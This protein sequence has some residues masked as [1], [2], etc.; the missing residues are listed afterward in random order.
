MKP[1]DY[2]SRKGMKEISWEEFH[3]MCKRLAQKISQDDFDIILGIARGGLYPATLIAGMLRKEVY[4]IRITRRENDKVKWEKPI[5]K[6]DVPSNVKSKKVLIIDD[7]SD[8]GETLS[9]VSKR[10]REKRAK[11]V[12]TAV[13]LLHSRS[14]SKPNYSALNSDQ[15]IVFPWDTQILVDGKWQLHPELAEAMKFHKKR[16][17]SK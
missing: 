7:V 3:Q 1:Y 6:V 17:R 8:S 13:F 2:K 10:A 11:K 14:K 16:G 5:W 15:C 4:P 12:K 9:I